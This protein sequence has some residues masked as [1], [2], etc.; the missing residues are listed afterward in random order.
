MALWP[1]G[2]WGRID[3]K[4]SAFPAPERSPSGGPTRCKANAFPVRPSTRTGSASLNR[5][6]MTPATRPVSCPRTRECGLCSGSVHDGDERLRS[7]CAVGEP[8]YRVTMHPDPRRLRSLFRSCHG[9]SREPKQAAK[10]LEIVGDG[11]VP[12]E[13][14]GRARCKGK[15]GSTRPLRLYAI[16]FR[17]A[18]SH[19]PVAPTPPPFRR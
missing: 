2:P 15:P 13:K 17:H 3:C 1:S 18:E 7:S 5:F 8:V 19:P 10:P 11:C 14:H 12:L 16:P 9:K 4:S 6:A